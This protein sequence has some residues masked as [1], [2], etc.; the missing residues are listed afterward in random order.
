[1]HCSEFQTVTAGKFKRTLTPT[2]RVTKEDLDKSKEELEEIFI[3]FR[4]FVKQNRPKL[5]I[6]KVAT[7]ETWF[8]TDALERGL[9]D[10]LKTADEVLM[11]FVDRGYNVFEVEYSPPEEIPGSLGDLLGPLGSKS[12]R[13]GG[14]LIRRFFRWIVQTVSDEITAELDTMDQSVEKKYLAQDTR[15]DRFRARR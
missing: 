7:G 1:M 13:T 8:G 15:A 4:D 14:S 3:L 10:E 11:D 2:K 5:D 12:P 6:E 9:C